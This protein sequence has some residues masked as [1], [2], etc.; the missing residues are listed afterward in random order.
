MKP[1]YF[2]MAFLLCGFGLSFIYLIFRLKQWSHWQGKKLFLL[3]SGLVLSFASVIFGMLYLRQFPEH[4]REWINYYNLVFLIM[5]LLVSLIFYT[6]IADMV[7]FIQKFLKLITQKNSLTKYYLLKKNLFSKSNLSSKEINQDRRRFLSLSSLSLGSVAVGNYQAHQDPQINHFV[8][9]LKDLPKEFSG[10]KIAQ[11]SDLHIGPMIGKN[12]VQ[13]VVELT[14]TLNVDLIALTGDI[15]DGPLTSI[16]DE[17]LPLKNLKAKE[18]VFFITGNHEYYWGTELW[19]QQFEKFGFKILL[20]QHVVLKKDSA[21]IV[22]AGVTDFDASRH[23]LSQAS[24]PAKALIGAPNDAKKILLA[25]QPKSY[26]AA[27]SAKFD[28]QLSGHTHGGQFFPWSLFVAVV[29]P[30]YR[31]LNQHENLLIYTSTGTGFWGPPLR[32]AIPKEIAVIELQPETKVSYSN[33]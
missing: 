3:M 32:F 23:D 6:F 26:K 2:F 19:L 12:Y 11:I 14:N 7:L 9:K 20:N 10:F 27:N 5:G 25:H 31:G 33:S 22:L 8:V 4:M 21:E 18:G 24:D 30:Y 28:L 13:R 29:Q 17:V 16:L 1:I 15:I